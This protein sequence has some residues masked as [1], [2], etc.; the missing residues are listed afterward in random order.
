MWYGCLVQLFLSLC[1]Y[2]NQTFG[3]TDTYRVGLLVNANFNKRLA[4]GWGVNARLEAREIFFRDSYPQ[5]IQAGLWHER[6]LVAVTGTKKLNQA[7]EIGLGYM[8]HY[9]NRD[10]D[11]YF[12]H[13]VLV[14]YVYSRKLGIYRCAHRVIAEGNFRAQTN[15]NY[16]LRY[17]FAM[18]LP[19]AGDAVDA[20]EFYARF[21]TEFLLTLPNADWDYE[22]RAAPFVGYRLGKS[23]KIE[24]GIDYRLSR[25]ANPS[26]QH[27]AWLHVA[28]FYSI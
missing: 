11:P 25:L 16:R 18:E 13:R 23:Q 12:V 17:R 26:K 6:V 28:Y 5:R 7:H 14:Q 27:Q 10:P 1:V 2:N 15:T 20:G 4:H 22:Y 9:I 19:F 8:A 24:V 3:Q 21:A